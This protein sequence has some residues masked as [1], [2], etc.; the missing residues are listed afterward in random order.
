MRHAYD[1]GFSCRTT[2]S[3]SDIGDMTADGRLR[4]FFSFQSARRPTPETLTILKRTPG[5]SP[6]A[7]P[8]RPKPEIRT[9]SF[10]S[11]K[12]R[13]PSFCKNGAIR[14]GRAQRSHGQS[15]GRSRA[16]QAQRSTVGEDRGHRRTGTNAVTFFP[17]LMSWT[18]TH[19]RMA[20]LGCLASTPTFSSTMP[21]AWEEPPVG[22][23]L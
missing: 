20:E 7:L 12:L 18:R 11:T 16:H 8:R 13:Q 3:S 15:P 1:R 17:F 10:S 5:I 21:F 4:T 2:G 19:L 6:L 22:E 23:V 9:S 14:I